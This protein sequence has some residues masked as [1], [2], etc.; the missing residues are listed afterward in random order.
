MN[1]TVKV[2]YKK[3][4][5]NLKKKGYINLNHRLVNTKDDLVDMASIFRSPEYETFRIVYMNDNKV[6]GYESV[7]TKTPTSVHLFRDKNRSYTNLEKGFYKVKDRMKRLNANGYYLVHNHPSGVAK[8]SRDD[9]R[10]T[11]D[12]FNKVDGFKGHLILGTDE[13]AWIDRDDNSFENV[14]VIN[15]EPINFKKADKFS[16]MMNKKSEFNVKISSRTDLVNFI[17]HINT[18]KDYSTAI[19]TDASN[20]VRMILDVPNSMLNQSIEQINGFF[21]NQGRVCGATKVLFATKDEN[22]FKRSL[23]HLTYGTLTDSIYYKETE[24]NQIELCDVCNEQPSRT[25][26]ESEEHPGRKPLIHF[27]GIIV[28]NG[29]LVLS[30]SGIIDY[31]EE[32]DNYMEIPVENIDKEEYLNTEDKGEP[33]EGE[34]KVLFKRVGKDP[35][36]KIIP[37]TLEAKQNLVGGL[38]ECVPYDDETLL[39]CNE[40]GKLIGMK[41]NLCFDYDYI[42]GDCFLIGDDYENSD[43]KSLTDKQIK[44]AKLDWK[45]RSFIYDQN[46]RRGSSK[47]QEKE[48]EI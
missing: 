39:I 22:T 42:A 34:I 2:I 45:G 26:F 48:Q 43:F 5:E 19:L 14:K 37:N 44:E 21:K 17:H 1:R 35:I 13:Y 10:V 6:A 18:S 28:N 8:A 9:I 38:I 46:Q 47:Q 3:V 40:E 32:G 25:L 23:N 7:S 31:N 36:V 15:S 4:T 30:D 33:K 16:K 20:R 41:P 11:R 27:G 29:Q 24:G 12:F